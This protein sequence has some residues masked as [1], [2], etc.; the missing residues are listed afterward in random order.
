MGRVYA[1]EPDKAKGES[2]FPPGSRLVQVD[3]P[4]TAVNAVR[5]EFADGEG[6][7]LVTRYVGNSSTVPGEVAATETVRMAVKLDPPAKATAPTEA[8]AAVEFTPA[9]PPPAKKGK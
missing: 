9:E 1:T 6:D 3:H 8:P 7:A 4:Y 5:V 2:P